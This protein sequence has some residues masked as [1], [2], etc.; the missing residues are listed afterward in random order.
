MNLQGPAVK[1]APG[2]KPIYWV[3]II[4]GFN[5]HYNPDIDRYAEQ[6]DIKIM[7]LPAHGT[8]VIQPLDIGVFSSFKA[9]H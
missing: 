7:G 1:H 5:R 4:D 2:H 8:H 3:L 9:Q 6:F